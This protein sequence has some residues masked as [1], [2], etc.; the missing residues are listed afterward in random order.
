MPVKGMD[1]IANQHTTVF[2]KGARISPSLI[3]PTRPFSNGNAVIDKPDKA[4]A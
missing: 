1:I 2:K 3:T 4:A